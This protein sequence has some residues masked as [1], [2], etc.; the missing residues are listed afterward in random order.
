MVYLMLQNSNRADETRGFFFYYGQG[1]VV[2]S[3]KQAAVEHVRKSLTFNHREFAFHD[4]H[5]II[6]A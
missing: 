2:E 1:V 4:D 3:V 5:E 6:I